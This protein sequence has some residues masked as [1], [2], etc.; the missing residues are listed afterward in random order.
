VEKLKAY[1]LTSD[2]HG[3]TRE[4][5]NLDKAIGMDDGSLYCC[6]WGD[7]PAKLQSHKSFH[8]LCRQGDAL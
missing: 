3:S 7:Q 4:Y 6:P 2:E 8:M 5:E 1:L